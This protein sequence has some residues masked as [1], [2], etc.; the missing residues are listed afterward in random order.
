[1]MMKR[2]GFVL[3]S[4]WCSRSWEKNQASACVLSGLFFKCAVR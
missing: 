3:V 1:M 2:S 4:D